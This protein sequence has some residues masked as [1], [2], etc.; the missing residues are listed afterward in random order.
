MNIGSNLK[1]LRGKRT[2]EE[3]ANALGISV[4]AY[5]KYEN[6]L[7]SPRDDMKLKI[8]AYYKKPVGKIF[9]T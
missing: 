9:F 4:S 3:V 1:A 7:R 5:R 6:D 8:A 2:Q